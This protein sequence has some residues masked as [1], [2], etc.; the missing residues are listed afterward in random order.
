MVEGFV[1]CYPRQNQL[2]RRDD[3]WYLPQP[4]FYQYQK[5]ARSRKLRDKYRK[6]ASRQEREARGKQPP[7]GTR[8]SQGS[9]QT[10]KKEKLFAESLERFQ[11]QLR[12]LKSKGKPVAKKAP[13]SA[14]KKTKVKGVKKKT[15]KKKAAKKKAVKKAKKTKV[16][17]QPSRKKKPKSDVGKT[18]IPK[19]AK[20]ARTAAK[21]TRL[22]QSGRVR[23]TAHVSSRGRRKQARRDSANR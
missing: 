7:K 13:T 16:A 21:K 6:L 8:R 23:T 22:K 14:G 9:G 11:Q 1:R 12:K 20:K 19:A 4:L 2:I 3:F 18:K 15:A 5:I 17:K 10:R